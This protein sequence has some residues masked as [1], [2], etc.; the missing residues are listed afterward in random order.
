[1][2]EFNHVG[3]EARQIC[4]CPFFLFKTICFY[5]YSFWSYEYV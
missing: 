1:M 5:F 3:V 4:P 2:S